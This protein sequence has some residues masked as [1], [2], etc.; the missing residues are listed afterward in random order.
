MTNKE[1]LGRGWRVQKEIDSLNEIV[2]TFKADPNYTE[3][4]YDDY[5]KTAINFI[6]KKGKILAEIENAIEAVDNTVYRIILRKR[7]IEFKPISVIAWEEHYDERYM[8]KLLRKA[9]EAIKPDIKR[10]PVPGV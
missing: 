2:D 9:E 8:R 6:Y 1:W 7:Y 4:A 3:G 10:H 5:I